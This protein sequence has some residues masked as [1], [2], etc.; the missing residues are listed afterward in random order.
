[1]TTPD[2]RYKALKLAKSFLNDLIDPKKTPRV[3]KGIRKRAYWVLRHYPHEYELIE[4]K[5]HNPKL[6]GEDYLKEE[7]EYHSKVFNKDLK[8]LLDS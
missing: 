6:L 4:L 2:E 3:P 7:L 1:M 8:D 5:K